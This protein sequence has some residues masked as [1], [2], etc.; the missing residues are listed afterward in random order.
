[1]DRLA[2][3]TVFVRVA[4][5]KS[6]AAAAQVLDMSPTMVANHIRAQ[7]ARLGVRLIE[8]TTR[9]QVL[10]DVGATY[11]ERCREVLASVEAADGVA[12]A[13]RTRPQGLLRVTA[14]VS[15]GAHRL[16]PVIAAFCRAH[17]AVQVELDLN[18]RIVDLEED[19]FHAGIRS[20]RAP[21]M[22]LH[23]VGLKPST[24][25]VAASPAYLERR[26]T[27]QHPADLAAH[28]SLAFTAWGP[29][30]AWRFSHGAE[31]VVVPVKGP[32]SVNS[33]QALLQAAVAGLGVIVQADVL[34]EESVA[35]GTLVRLLTDWALP[36]RPMHLVTSRRA[37]PSAKLR[38][39]VEFVGER[40]GPPA[41]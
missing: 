7:E 12:E 25:W 20:G 26:G 4:E 28:D 6:F 34:L 5:A 17:P 39:F 15:C 11:L 40:L 24:M 8:R 29:G 33:G 27:P 2:S 32:L 19:G 10:T 16:T 13:M 30:H 37:P 22:H 23:A 9:R 38:S 36:M 31:T 35:S 41:R 21:D 18:D 1:M 3:M 14:P